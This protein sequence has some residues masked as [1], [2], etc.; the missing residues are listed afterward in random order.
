MSFLGAWAG[1][2]A[3]ATDQSLKE[4][5]SLFLEQDK[6]KENRRQFDAIQSQELDIMGKQQDFTMQLEQ[7]KNDFSAGQS[8]IGREFTL[9]MDAIGLAQQ[10]G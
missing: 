9:G 10:G 5:Q 3:S 1:T 2:A 6:L 8:E 7:F 4:W